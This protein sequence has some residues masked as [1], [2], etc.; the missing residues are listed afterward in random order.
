MVI[1]YYISTEL[2][3]IAIFVSRYNSR[4]LY[5]NTLSRRFVLYALAVYVTARK[6]VRAAITIMCSPTRIN[7]TLGITIERCIY[8]YYDC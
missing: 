2:I 4:T 3:L 7:S 5:C 6:S 8:C 1:F